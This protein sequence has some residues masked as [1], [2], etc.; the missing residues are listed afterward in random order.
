MN[1]E[2]RR[3]TTLLTGLQALTRGDSRA[4]ITVSDNGP[5]V[6]PDQR[7]AMKER[8]TRGARTRAPGSGLGLALVEQQ[9]HLHHGTLHLGESPS[10]GL[11]AVLALPAA[12]DH[13]PHEPGSG[14]PPSV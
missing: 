13:G 2:H 4:R 8:F 7:L 11:Q 9:A 5:G 14:G 6:P 12:G 10:S 1:A 3:I